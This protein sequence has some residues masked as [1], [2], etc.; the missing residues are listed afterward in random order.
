MNFVSITNGKKTLTF[1]KDT[2]WELELNKNVMVV[3]I[4]NEQASLTRNELTFKTQ[5]HAK[6][7]HTKFLTQLNVN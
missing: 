6:D 4:L 7:E 5:R 1:K 2:V 3:C